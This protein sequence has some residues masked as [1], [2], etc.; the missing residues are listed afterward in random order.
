MPAGPR[1]PAIVTMTRH[2]RLALVGPL[3]ALVAVCGVLETN[4][5]QSIF[6]RAAAISWD[7]PV[8]QLQDELAVQGAVYADA[9]R[10]L[11]EHTGSASTA[12]GRL[13]LAS[14]PVRGDQLAVSS[15]V[16]RSPPAV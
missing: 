16:T 9:A 11:R 12:S 4:A 2:V 10:Q 5:Q 6:W 15:G 13:P 7:S 3:L 8:T 1:V 14:D